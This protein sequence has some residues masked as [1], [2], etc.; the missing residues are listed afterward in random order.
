MPYKGELKKTTPYTLEIAGAANAK[1]A[2]AIL[3]INKRERITSADPTTI[4]IAG[5]FKVD[6]TLGVGIDRL[7]IFVTPPEGGS[8][9]VTVTQGNVQFSDTCITDVVLTYDGIA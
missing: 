2:V 3:K 4:D 7:M 9:R 8:L 5:A 6:D 1:G